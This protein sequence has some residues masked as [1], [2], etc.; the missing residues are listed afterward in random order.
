MRGDRVHRAASACSGRRQR[1]RADHVRAAGLLAV[2]HV[3]PGDV[4]GGDGVD[5]AAAAV[6][7][8]ALQED[9]AAADERARA[10]RRVQLVRGQRDEVEVL[11][12]VAGRTS[13]ARWGASCAASTRMRAPTA[14]ALRARRW[15]GCTNPVTFE[16]PDTVTS[17]TRS[18]VQVRAAGRSRPRPAGPSG[19]TPAR[20]TVGPRAPGQVVRV[21]LHQRRQHHRVLRQRV[22]IRASLLMASVVFLP[23]TTAAVS[24]SAPTKRATVRCASS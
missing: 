1:D 15:T 9:V 16:A 12:V 14:C 21:V 10:E 13:I 18:A 24:G 11:R 4:V 17:A 6:L 8:R 22:A 7:G 3:R 20:T 5:R 23:N 19:V 2:G